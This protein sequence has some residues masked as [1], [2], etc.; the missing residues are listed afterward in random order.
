M[1][2]VYQVNGCYALTCIGVVLGMLGRSVVCAGVLVLRM[3]QSI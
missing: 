1:L 3:S 2:L